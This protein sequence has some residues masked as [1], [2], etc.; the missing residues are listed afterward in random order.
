MENKI[1]NVA[2]TPDSYGQNP[3]IQRPDAGASAVRAASGPDPADMRLV[4]EEDQASG[5]YVYKQVS[6]L[7]GEVL[8]QF[9]REDV[10]KMRERVDYEAGAVVRTKA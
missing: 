5:S 8:M 7:T 6:R 1:A 4:I 9:P 2:P 3:P 10:L